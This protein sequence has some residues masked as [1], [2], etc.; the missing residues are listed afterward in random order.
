MTQELTKEQWAELYKWR[1]EWFKIGSSCEPAKRAD[2]EETIAKLYASIGEKKPK[3]L[4]CDSPLACSTLID[5]M[6]NWEKVKDTK[7]NTLMSGSHV[8]ENVID[9]FCNIPEAKKKVASKDIRFKARQYLSNTTTEKTYTYFWG[10]LDSYWI[11]FYLFCRDVIGVTYDAKDSESL[12][13]WAIL[14]KS[15]FFWYP[16]ENYCIC[17]DRPKTIH[18]D[19][20]P[21][22]P[23]LHNATAPAVTFRDDWKIYVYQGVLIDDP[24]LIEKPESITV[25]SIIDEENAELRRIKLELMTYEKFIKES[26]AKT[27]DRG[28]PGDESALYKVDLGE[29]AE[30]VTILQVINST[31][32][33]DGSF[34]K[35]FLR[36][37][38]N[39]ESVRQ[40]VA[41]TFCFD[42]PEDYKPE[43]ET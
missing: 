23:R 10:S 25:Q 20:E 29:E 5:L 35:Y 11:A 34:R 31:A 8:Q 14:A 42:N 26:K 41:W 37:P 24:N 13:Q 19:M 28:E 4:W 2:T 16:F 15:C 32:E 27:L 43:V 17:S 7:P 6:T 9:T 18:W 30:P 21:E 12:D 38:P 3:F 40:A 33:A 36:V 22:T 1:D 39:M